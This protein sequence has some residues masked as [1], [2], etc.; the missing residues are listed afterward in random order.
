MLDSSSDGGY[1]KGVNTGPPLMTCLID[2]RPLESPDYWVIDAYPCYMDFC[3]DVADYLQRN[4]GWN[5]TGSQLADNYY[6]KR[7]YELGE[8]AEATAELFY[9]FEVIWED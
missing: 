9:E 5:T 1:I 4:H 3:E 7:E 2:P 8:S 6:V